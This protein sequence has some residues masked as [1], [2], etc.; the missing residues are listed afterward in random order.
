[1]SDATAVVAGAVVG[2]ATTKRPVIDPGRQFRGGG[3]TGRVCIKALAELRDR[4]WVAEHPEDESTTPERVAL[5]KALRE[6]P[7]RFRERLDE[8]ELAHAATV[9]RAKARKGAAE[10]AA[11]V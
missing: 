1:M 8:L 6:E 11:S 9:A 2:P 7:G 3:K 5:Q 10:A 4:R